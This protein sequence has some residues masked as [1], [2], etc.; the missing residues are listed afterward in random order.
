MR[1]AAALVALA[2]AYVLLRGH[3]DAWPAMVRACVA[4]LCLF[5]GFGLWA[6]A[7]AG[8]GPVLASR[9]R[10]RLPDY[11][12]LGAVVLAIEGAF[13]LF[14]N[15]APEPLETMAGRFEEWLRPMAAKERR[16]EQAG[17]RDPNAGNWLWDRHGERRLPLRTN[18]KPGNRPEVFLRPSGDAAS[19]LSSRIYV[20]AFALAEYGKGV[21][22]VGDVEPVPLPADND[23][24]V[25]LDEVRSGEAVG[26]RVYHSLERSG[27]NP[28]L[29]LQ[30][31]A[32]AR[33]P[34]V[35]KLAP[36][37]HLL[38]PPESENGYEYDTL[39][40]PVMLDDLVGLDVAVPDAVP[41]RFLELPGGALGFRIADLAR[42]V[43]GEGGLVE[44]LVR[45]RNHLR[46][47]LEYSLVTENED[48]RDPL[49]NFMFDEQRGHCEFFATAGA[50]LAR[51]AGVPSRIC[52]GW[53]GGTY[54]ESGRLF[55]FR[56]REAHAWAEVWLEGWGWVVLDPT[57]PTA[58]V[59]GRPDLAAP[60]EPPPG[61]DDL[62]A[63]SEVI[64]EGGRSWLTG[65][66]ALF[67]VPVAVLWFARRRRPR[68]SAGWDGSDAPPAPYWRVFLNGCMLRGLSCR[69]G[70]TMR[71]MLTSLNDP[72]E[73][74][75]DL[76]RYHYAVR[77]E[78]RRRDAGE[79]RR[80]AKSLRAWERSIQ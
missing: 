37:L 55:V 44:R 35:S 6:A 18:Y 52:Y 8:E 10:V 76:L 71:A 41:D 36:G 17:E 57:P 14:F 27:Q 50:L 5:A 48:G 75:A 59:N 66:A 22:S 73:I 32:A 19:L 67:G 30:G 54:Y 42:V 80:L 29:G 77:Y 11:L 43:Q 40:R 15:V 23:G 65:L 4:V 46:T 68:D 13:L 21:W 33:L 64:G 74:A 16:E 62:L 12:S 49:E 39:S 79:E 45:I 34:Q 28:V 51:S 2:A 31:L 56:S 72:P 1:N 58:F 25:R 53:S 47:T 20:H 70:R 9:R 69:P 26:C 24:W 61:A 3:P 63:E 60:D 7:H 38:P 78:G